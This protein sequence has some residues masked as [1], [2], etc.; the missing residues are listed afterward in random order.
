MSISGLWNILAL[1]PPLLLFFFSTEMR[2]PERNC[3]KKNFNRWSEMLGKI[4]GKMPVSPWRI[5]LQYVSLLQLFY[6]LSVID[7]KKNISAPIFNVLH[8]IEHHERWVFFSILREILI[9][10][11]VLYSA[12]EKLLFFRYLKNLTSAVHSLSSII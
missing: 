1:F 7:I 4:S 9:S 6:V 2:G 10:W 11:V 3:E 5:F 8:H 12:F